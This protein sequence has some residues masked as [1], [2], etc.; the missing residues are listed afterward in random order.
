MLITIGVKLFTSSSL[1]KDCNIKSYVTSC[2]VMASQ[3]QMQK[4]QMTK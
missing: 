4:L 2:C 1:E 3:T